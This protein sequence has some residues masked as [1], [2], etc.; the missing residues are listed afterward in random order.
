ME[1]KVMYC[2]KR[3]NNVL[4]PV[5]FCCAT[6]GFGGDKERCTDIA[7]IRRSAFLVEKL[8]MKSSLIMILEIRGGER[9]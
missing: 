8:I 1:Q 7:V 5:H 3:S 2:M 6:G 4:L 9:D